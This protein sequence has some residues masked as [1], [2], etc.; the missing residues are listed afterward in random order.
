MN[1]LEIATAACDELGL[2]PPSAIAGVNDKTA[3]QIF[4]L[5][6]RSGDEIYQV[7]GWTTL[8]KER[9]VNI[10]QPINTVGDLVANS[11]LITNIPSTAGIIANEW[12]VAGNSIPI[13]ARVA[14]VVDINTIRMDSPASETIVG[15]GII[16]AKDTY[17]VPEDFKWWIARTMWDRTNRWELIGPIAPWIDQWQRSGVVTTGP[18]RRWRQ[19]GDGLN[20]WRL[21]PPPTASNDYPGTLV[22]ELQSKFW[23]IGA[24]G[25]YKERFTAD[26]DEP[27]ID[28]QAI[29]LAI[30]WRLWQAKGF[31]YLPLQAECN[32]YLS[33]LASR[34]G[35]AADLN[36]G[37]PVHRATLLGPWN[38]QDGYFPGPI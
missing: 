10:A 36:M 17:D 35:G 20:V 22:F 31:D 8:Q 18:R 6:N 19:I 1:L 27:I 4:A 15:T 24:D 14:E 21:W 25:V 12:A 9:I 5:A 7:N 3:R 38:V 26:D 37:R 33:R 2:T 23:V 28:S 32:D 11:D 13:A 29:I 16:F 34:D 30:K